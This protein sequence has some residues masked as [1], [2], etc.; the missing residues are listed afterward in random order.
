MNS[1][2]LDLAVLHDVDQG[3]DTKR[4]ATWKRSFTV[5]EGIDSVKVNAKIG[6]SRSYDHASKS[7]G[8]QASFHRNRLI[9]R[10]FK[11]PKNYPNPTLRK[12]EYSYSKKRHS[13]LHCRKQHELRGT[14][15]N[16]DVKPK[17][18]VTE[19]ESAFEVSVEVP[20]AKR[21][22]VEIGFD[23]GVLDITASRTDSIPESWRP[24]GS[25]VS[26]PNYRLK[27]SVADS[28]DA[29]KI[30]ASVGERH[31]QIEPPSERSGQTAVDL[32]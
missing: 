21:E 19:T 28:I 2:Q 13:Q 29:G 23:G 7:R 22:S 18:A 24:L 31:S 1:R 8:Q 14:P 27:F 11:K 15:T 5:P 10:P 16:R 17:Y 6:G 9:F 26:R 3:D 12:N 25:V 20:G 4:E 30:S 32:S